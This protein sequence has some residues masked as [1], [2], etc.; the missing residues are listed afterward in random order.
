MTN[1]SALG[2][3]VAVVLVDRA[4]LPWEISVSAK[5]PVMSLVVS[6]ST[7]L[8]CLFTDPIQ[9]GKQL[10]DFHDSLKIPMVDSNFLHS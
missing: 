7:V 2:S 8:S 4:S 9:N 10:F 6:A 1:S 3:Y 5:Q